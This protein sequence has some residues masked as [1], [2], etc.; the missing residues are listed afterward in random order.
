M[1]KE[2]LQE[3]GYDEIS[4]EKIIKWYS[5]YLENTSYRYILDTFKYF[6]KKGYSK[7][8]IVKMTKLLP[9]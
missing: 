1:L 6:E 8:D 5:T 2:L 4:I 7:K 3:I 9:Y